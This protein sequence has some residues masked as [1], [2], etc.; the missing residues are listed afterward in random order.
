MF[1][2]SID[3]GLHREETEIMGIYSDWDPSIIISLPK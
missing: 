2:R 1:L 3:N